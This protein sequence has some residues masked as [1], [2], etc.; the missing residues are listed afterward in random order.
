MVE[1]AADL[2][3]LYVDHFH[4][5]ALNS[6]VIRE[7]FGLLRCSRNQLCNLCTGYKL[8]A[9]VLYA[10]TSQC[11]S[12]FGSEVCFITLIYMYTSH[13]EH[14]CCMYVQVLQVACVILLLVLSWRTY[15]RNWD[16]Q[17]EESL[18]RCVL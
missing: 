5:V 16:W 10:F 17:D 6:I 2:Q 8:S 12:P 13:V 15:L 7:L 4:T 3:L 11:N 14:Y 1:A 9:D 18:Y